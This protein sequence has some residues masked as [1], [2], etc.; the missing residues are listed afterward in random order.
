MCIYIVRQNTSLSFW[1]RIEKGRQDDWITINDNGVESVTHM[2]TEALLVLVHNVASFPLESLRT[3][4][5]FIFVLDDQ[6]CMISVAE[7][8]KRYSEDSLLYLYLYFFK[9]WKE[10]KL[11]FFSPS[12]NHH[13]SFL[14]L[15]SE[16]LLSIKLLIVFVYVDIRSECLSLIE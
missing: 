14:F 15:Y 3:I 2:Y 8:K 13:R 7:E 1:W 9:T 5:V 11:D 16:M 6:W 10:K 4:D 12:N